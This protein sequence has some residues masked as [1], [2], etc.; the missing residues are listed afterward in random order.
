MRNENFHDEKTD[1]K[2]LFLNYDKN[3]NRFSFEN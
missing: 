3:Q 2:Y 1:L